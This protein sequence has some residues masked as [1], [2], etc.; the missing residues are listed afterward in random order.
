KY[1]DTAAVDGFYALLEEAEARNRRSLS[2]NLRSAAQICRAGLKLLLQNCQ[3]ALRDLTGRTD[4][5]ATLP[6]ASEGKP[7]TP[8]ER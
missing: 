5:T 2:F 4:T 8:E 3:Q 6:R 1:G 7:L